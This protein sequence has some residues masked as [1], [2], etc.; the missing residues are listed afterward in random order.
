ML[1][2]TFGLVFEIFLLLMESKSYK[3]TP[4]D[5]QTNHEF[6]GEMNALHLV[7]TLWFD[8]STQNS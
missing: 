4:G 2:R 5:D 3:V 8:E 7:S 1:D 6:N